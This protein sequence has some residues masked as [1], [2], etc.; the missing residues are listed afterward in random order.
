MATA[1]EGLHAKKRK[2][3]GTRAARQLRAEGEVPAIVYG[4]QEEP[5]PIQV[6][7]EELDRALRHHSRTFELHIGRKKETVLLK[8]VQY[9]AL[10]AEIIHADF[11][12]IAMDENVTVEVRI[13]LKGT[14]KQEHAV[15]Q[16][17]LDAVQVQC[18]PSHI[19]ESLIAHTAEM[20]LGDTLNVSD[21]EVP[22][23]IKV[24]TDPETIVAALTAVAAE[25]VEEAAPVAAPGA[26]EP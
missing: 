26:E 7:Y 13:V 1:A 2:G 10:G 25:V 5:E 22:E 17:T 9:D 18:L 15:L 16:Q 23:G 14:P 21:L 11:L 19:P 20:Q 24:L 8:K 4:H 6:P 3:Q 12:R